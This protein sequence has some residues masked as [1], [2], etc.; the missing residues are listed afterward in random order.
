MT[1]EQ[2]W[3]VRL[4]PQAAKTLAELPEPARETVRDVLDIAVRAPWG[5]PQWNGPLGTPPTMRSQAGTT[6]AVAQIAT[7]A[8]AYGQWI[9]T[10]SG[11]RVAVAYPAPAH[12]S[13][14][15]R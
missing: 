10:G 4:S 12:A 6:K 8:F 13:A 2:P 11:S 14:S 7:T 5:W 3:A 9:T 1:A 15:A